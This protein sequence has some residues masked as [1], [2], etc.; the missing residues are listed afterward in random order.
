MIGTI[1]KHHSQT[2]GYHNWIV[3]KDVSSSK[4]CICAIISSKK[5]THS[6]KIGPK[7]CSFL[8]KDSYI[9]ID[10]LLSIDKDIIEKKEKELVCSSLLNKIKITFNKFFT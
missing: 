9:Q 5:S 8:K 6:L 3:L 7:D 10:N 1:F 2:H 4:Y